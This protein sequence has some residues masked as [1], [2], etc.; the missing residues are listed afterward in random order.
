MDST[1]TTRGFVGVEGVVQEDAGARIA[2]VH[3]LPEVKLSFDAVIKIFAAAPGDI[4][5]DP[6]AELGNVCEESALQVADIGV[7]DDA[8]L[9]LIRILGVSC[10]AS[11]VGSGSECQNRYRTIHI[12]VAPRPLIRCPRM[13]SSR[14][15]SMILN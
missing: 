5:A 4:A 13:A 3:G 15:N 7:G 12:H 6:R 10:T 2:G 1:P 9:L 14:I 8:A 11:D